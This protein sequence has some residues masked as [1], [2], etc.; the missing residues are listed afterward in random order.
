MILIISISNLGISH[1]ISSGDGRWDFSIIENSTDILTRELPDPKG[2]SNFKM[3][4][5][6]SEI[7]FHGYASS[8]TTDVLLSVTDPDGIT[9]QY[10]KKLEDMKI[11]E[12]RKI[13]LGSFSDIGKYEV[14][15]KVMPPDGISD[16]I[17]DRKILSYDFGVIDMDATNKVIKLKKGESKITK[18]FGNVKK[19]FVLNRFPIITTMIFPDGSQ[20]NLKT[21][22]TSS[23][24]F[25]IPISL[26]DKSQYGI[27]QFVTKYQNYQSE[28]VRLYVNSFYS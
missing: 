6:N 16:H 2:L 4:S 27:Y 22:V 9:K 21:R 15:I 3:F 5:V 8:G 17:F 7:M 13:S 23:G 1:A 12:T 20:K 19:N 14:E 25:E 24:Y 26:N 10:V 18:I 11:N 28:I